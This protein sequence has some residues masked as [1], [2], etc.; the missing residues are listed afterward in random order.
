MM[1]TPTHVL[2]TRS[3]ATPVQLVSSPNGVYLV[4]E[5]EWNK[6]VTPAFELRPKLGIFC[7]GTLVVGYRLKPIVVHKPNLV[8]PSVTHA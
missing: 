3:K 6:P 7:C 5:Q 1:F 8:E 4:T 2:E